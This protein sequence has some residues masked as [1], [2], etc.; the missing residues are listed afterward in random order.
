MDYLLDEAFLQRLDRLQFMTKGRLGGRLSGVHVSPRAGMSV[1]F[2]DYREYHPGDDIRYVD[3]N[4]YGR[5][6]RLLVKSFIHESDL[7]IYLLVDVSGSM[8]LG[9]PPKIEFAARLAL[10]LAHVGL[11]SMDRVGVF[12]FAHRLLASIP[13]QHGTSHIRRVYKALS[14]L[15]AQDETAFEPAVMEF[16]S[17]TRE[18]GL[19]IILSDML[20]PTGI[21]EAVA[22][23]QYRGD[24]VVVLQILAPEE[25]DPAAGGTA[26]I[27]DVESGRFVT[28]NLGSTT[29]ASY[30]ERF[31][32]HQRRIRT[33]LDEQRVPLFGVVTTDPLEEIIF[34]SLREG[35][36]VR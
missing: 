6:E 4:I 13:A 24:E 30:K 9:R 35:G 23:L 27:V 25:L 11:H 16:L 10:A 12:P 28:L 7:P 34:G 18:T 36:I 14:E 31:E 2:A 33:F 17:L 29:L 1:E 8:Q 20:F 21:E 22:R 26:Q 5:L 32:A 19:S 15:T 3:W